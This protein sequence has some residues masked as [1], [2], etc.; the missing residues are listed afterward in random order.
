VLERKDRGSGERWLPFRLA[1]EIGSLAGRLEAWAARSDIVDV[2]RGANPAIPP[3]LRD[4]QAE[5]WWGLLAIA[6][7]AGEPW[8]IRARLAAVSLHTG[9]DAEDSMSLSVLLLSHIRRVFEEAATDRI[10]TIDLLSALV[11]LEEGPWAR[12]WAADVEKSERPEGPPPR[13]AGADLSHKLKPF[14]RPD[15]K[16]IKPRVVRMPDGKTPRGYLVEDFADAFPRYLGSP[17]ATDAT[18]ATS[19]ASAVASV[20]SV[21]SPVPN[22]N[23]DGWPCGECGARS[24][25]GHSM[26]CLTGVRE[27]YGMEAA[28]A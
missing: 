16:P 13:K 18:N 15:G 20:A 27:R 4:R 19:L 10:T 7:A 21:A 6:D 25:V 28:G 14:R 1:R 26:S 22:G 3:E 12:W 11:D 9:R 24:P 8:S 23:E 17:D 2:L 5:T